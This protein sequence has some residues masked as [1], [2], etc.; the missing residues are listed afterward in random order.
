M[1]EPSNYRYDIFVSYSHADKQWVQGELLPRLESA[2]LRVCIDYRDFEIGVPSLINMERAVDNSLHT[3]AILTPGY[4][5]SEWCEFEVLLVGTNDPAGRRRKLI[6]ILLEACAL[7][8]RISLLTHADL[9]HIQDRISGLE[10]LLSQILSLKIQPNPAVENAS[11]FIAGPP[12]A[13]PRCFFGHEK[14]LKRLFDVL[15]GHPLQTRLSL[16]PAAAAKLRC[17]CT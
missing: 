3:L 4:V 13:H 17:F 10:R 1:P 16:A 2:G 15:K 8:A 9:T 12:I 6:P 7:P 14:S 5:E 11:P